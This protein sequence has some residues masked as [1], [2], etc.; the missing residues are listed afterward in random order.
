[1]STPTINVTI[2]D[3]AG[4]RQVFEVEHLEIDCGG[5]S[6][7]I[8]PGKPAFCRGFE[9]GVFTLDEGGKI[10]TLVVKHGMASLAGDAIHVVCEQAVT[11]LLGVSNRPHANPCPARSSVKNNFEPT[12]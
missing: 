2:V 12:T 8:R 9:H 10:T 5:G 6:V 3:S 7:D 11:T 4:V 1:M